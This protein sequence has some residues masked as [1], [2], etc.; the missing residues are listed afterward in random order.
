MGAAA[1]RERQ[2]EAITA[3]ASELGI[4]RDWKRETAMLSNE[5]LATLLSSIRRRWKR[6][7]RAVRRLPLPLRAHLL[8][9]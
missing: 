4:K 3:M 2:L 6:A 5:V 9:R 7:R 8:R 1:Q